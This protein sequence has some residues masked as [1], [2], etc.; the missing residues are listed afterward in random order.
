M[1]L[2][3]F[4]PLIVLVLLGA[5]LS[6]G[7]REGHDPRHVPSPLI[8]KPAPDFSLPALND[9]ERVVSKSDLLGEPYVLNVW[10]SWCPGC[11]VEHPLITQIAESGILPVY[12]LNW[13][14]ETS[15]ANRWLARFGDPYVVNLVDHDGGTAIDFGVYGAPETFVIDAKGIVRFKHVGPVTPNV[16]RE[17]IRPLAER[18]RGEG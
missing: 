1:N 6:W 15:N 4:I 2:K 18:I 3:L 5:T 10:G 16:I 13:K 17:Q 8:D 7:L 11:R 12:G 9:P 14:D